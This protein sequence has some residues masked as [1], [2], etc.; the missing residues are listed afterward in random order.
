MRDVRGLGAALRKALQTTRRAAQA[1]IKAAQDAEEAIFAYEQAMTVELEDLTKER[2]AL[3]EERQAFWCERSL[4]EVVD[5]ARGAN[6]GA[7]PYEGGGQDKGQSE[8]GRRAQ[9]AVSQQQ[10]HQQAHG[11]CG[12]EYWL[13]PDKRP[14]VLKPSQA[15]S[16]A[17]ALREGGGG[18]GGRHHRDRSR[19]RSRDRDRDRERGHHGG[20]EAVRARAT[21]LGLD[22]NASKHIMQFPPQ[23]ALRMLEHVTDHVRNP[24]AFV[25]KMCAREKEKQQQPNDGIASDAY[26]GHQASTDGGGHVERAIHDLGLDE[27]AA[28]VLR[29]ASAEQAMSLLEQ[30][31]DT[32]RNPS[33]FVMSLA[34]RWGLGKGGGG[35]GGGGGGKATLPGPSAEERLEEGCRRLSLDQMAMRMLRELV[36]E[37]A[38]RILDQISE[39]VRNPSAFVTAEVRKFL[40]LTADAGKGRGEGN[41]AGGGSKDISQ[42]VEHF[43]LQLELDSNCAEALQSISPQDAVQILERVASEFQS[44][45]NRSAFVYAEI[46]K[47]RPPPQLS[48]R[49][50]DR[51]GGG[52]GERDRGGSSDR[53]DRGDRDRGSDRSDR[54]RS[55][56]G[57]FLRT[58]PCKFFA[59]GRCKN[60]QDCRFSHT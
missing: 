26:G 44:I 40:P 12:D 33:A 50:D 56:G 49:K 57:G 60:G 10:Q 22:E 6:Q 14:P 24:S 31:D 55:G 37:Q 11:G 8:E 45:R 48:A 47:R 30:V 53:G 9:G 32:V 17:A 20:E 18:S 25:T 42:Q 54:E 7:D 52:G 36:P 19:S 41:G 5:S 23:Q 59:E 3:E 29:E 38:L 13:F 15:S 39:D 1:H 58:V 27:G 16:A 34:H 43:A 46:K 4:Q 2:S 28:R 51:A 21:E 35:R